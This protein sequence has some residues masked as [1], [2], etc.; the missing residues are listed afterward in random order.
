MNRCIHRHHFIF[1]SRFWSS[2]FNSFTSWCFKYVHT[3][4]EWIAFHPNFIE[5][6]F[7]CEYTWNGI[8][9]LF[10]FVW[11][12]TNRSR[13]KINKSFYYKILP[14]FS[15]SYLVDDPIW[16]WNSIVAIRII[17]IN[18]ATKRMSKRGIA[19]SLIFFF[20]KCTNAMINTYMFFF[21]LAFLTR[22]FFA[23]SY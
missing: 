15:K 1:I 14:F 11:T 2:L 20:S 3:Y 7:L 19:F 6:F 8:F 17:I 18:N 12:K 5:V 9:S 16:K 23:F 4:I 22:F 10:F 21:S 13:W